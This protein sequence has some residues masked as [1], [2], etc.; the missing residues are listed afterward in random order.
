MSGKGTKRRSRKSRT[1]W[2]YLASDSDEGIDFSDTVWLNVRARGAKL[3]SSIWSGAKLSLVDF[4]FADLRGA[5]CLELDAS[6]PAGQPGN[7][8]TATRF[9]DTVLNGANLAGALLDDATFTGSL[10]NDACLAR[11]HGHRAIFAGAVLLGVDCRGANL[12]RASLDGAILGAANLGQANLFGA[13]LHEV[14]SFDH[15]GCRRGESPR[16]SCIR[17]ARSACAAPTPRSGAPA[18]SAA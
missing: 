5:A 9:D 12:T 13:S 10:L 2:D 16:V 17:P 18:P 14:R 7:D 3:A 4:R 15:S 11:S 8:F 6:S 1:D